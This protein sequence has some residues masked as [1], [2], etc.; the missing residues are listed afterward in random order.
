MSNRNKSQVTRDGE[1][2]PAVVPGR[3]A[4]GVIQDVTG[5]PG[6]WTLLMVLEKSPEGI[7]RGI[8]LWIQFLKDPCGCPAALVCHL[9]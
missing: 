6:A 5:H 9:I 4:D 3:L 2:G 1:E 8:T 7:N